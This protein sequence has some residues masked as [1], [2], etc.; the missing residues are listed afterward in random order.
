MTMTKTSPTLTVQNLQ[1]HFSARD[2]I[3]KAVEDVSFSVAPGQIM[4]LVGESGSGKSMTAY[5]IM[6]L[7]DPPG[8]IVG[9]KILLKDQDLRALSP[10]A[11][12]RIRGNRI[13]M[14]FQDPMMTLNPVLRIDTQMIEA[15]LA[16]QKVSK[17][18]AREMARDALVRVGIASPDERLLAY[19]HQ[20]SG[21]MRQRVAIAIA[22]LNKPDL[23]ICDEPTTAL[24]VTIQGQIL[25]EMQKLCRESGT[26]LIWITHDLSV[27]AG[28]ADAVCVM[29]AGKVVESGSVQDVLEKP[30]H[31]YTYGLIASSPS[32]NLPGQPLR[33]IAGMT[34]S[35]LNLPS[36]CAFRTRC[37]RATAVCENT[38]PISRDGARTLR[39]F[40][41]MQD[42]MKLVPEANHD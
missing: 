29:Y 10:E 17:G 34:P 4:G 35:L 20:F 40:H 42:A 11:M 27:I 23:I 18:E 30:Q 12:R 26:A 22:L 7:I 13:A 3:A 21:G 6:G 16:H 19:P 1:M 32:R 31:P 38:P 15:V 28:L 8:K 14:I 2:G 9:G 25:Y 41:P 36:G 39:C 37:E 24:D 5:S 33:Q